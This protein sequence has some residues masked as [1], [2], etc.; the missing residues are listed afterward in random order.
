M[1]ST[2]NLH[3]YNLCSRIKTGLF[4]RCFPGMLLCLRSGI[5]VFGHIDHFCYLHTYSQEI[6]MYYI[7]FRTCRLNTMGDF[8]FWISLSLSLFAQSKD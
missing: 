8:T 5:V 4:M 7:L 6:L 2:D 1:K 3:S